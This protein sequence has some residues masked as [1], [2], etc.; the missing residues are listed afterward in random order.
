MLRV[1]MLSAVVVLFGSAAYAAE[2]YRAIFWNLE[3]GDS[4]ATHIASQAV[5]K[6]P[7]DVWGFSEVENQS[8]VNTI[9]AAL[10]A[11]NPGFDYVTKLSEDG[12]GDRLALL[13]RADRLTSVPYSGTAA[14][15]D[16]GNNFFEVDSVNVGDSV[17]PALGVQLKS[18]SG[19]MVVVLVNHLKC[20]GGQSNEDRREE[21]A[22][23]LNA[24][25]I[26]T[27]GIPI[28]SGGDFNIP[29][30]DGT[31]STAA[32]IELTQVWEYKVPQQTNVGTFR[33]GSVLDAV[34]VANDLPSWESTTTILERDGNS[35]ATSRT[36]SDNVSETDHRPLLLVVQSDTEER[37]ES[38]REAIADLESVLMRLKAELVRLEGAN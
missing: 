29:I 20:C 36:F 4:S 22:I 2:E 17:R 8:V 34:F 3:S 13:F 6:G 32:F 18:A 30:I 33:S 7:I 24:F 12:G 1:T 28:V 19:Q 5:A 38:L 14:V 27:P 37:L 15:D 23:Q 35:P 21:Q 31:S 11:A 16:L 10:E 26:S 9:E 25:A